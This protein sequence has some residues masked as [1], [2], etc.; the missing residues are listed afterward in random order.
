VPK[1]PLPVRRQSA[2]RISAGSMIYLSA[3]RVPPPHMEAHDD[4]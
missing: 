4:R 1:H 2:S 3:V